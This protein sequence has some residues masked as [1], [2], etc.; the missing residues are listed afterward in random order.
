MI[1]LVRTSSG[2][3]EV[4]LSGRMNG[5]GAYLC[6]SDACWQQGISKGQLER[7]LKVSL[8]GDNRQK[9]IQYGNSLKMRE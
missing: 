8:D 4:D 3:V 9:L 2:N 1:R 5:R 7:A 6:S